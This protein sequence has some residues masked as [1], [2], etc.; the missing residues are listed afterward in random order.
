M[1]D[2]DLTNNNFSVVQ[3]GPLRIWF[4][5]RTMVAFAIYGERRICENVWSRT[6]GKHLKW[7][8][9]GDRQAKQAR[10]SRSEF[11]E[12]WAKIGDCL[13]AVLDRKLLDP[14]PP[15]PAAPD[16]NRELLPTRRRAIV[17]RD[18][19]LDQ[20]LEAAVPP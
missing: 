11:L 17:V 9:G 4:S 5:Y 10:L 16:P 7:I 14:P 6:T 3:L 20:A 15:P 13:D 8:D 19:V 1:P 18:Q 12:E 2:I